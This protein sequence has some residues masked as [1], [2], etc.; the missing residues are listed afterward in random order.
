[1]SSKIALSSEDQD[2]GYGRG[3]SMSEQEVQRR[4]QPLKRM[5]KKVLL[6]G[7]TEMPFF[8]MTTN[9][10]E[11]DTTEE[12]SYVSPISGATLFSSEAKFDSGTG[13][14]SFTQPVSGGTILEREDPRDAKLPVEQ[15]RR[16]VLDAASMT[17]LGHVFEDG[18]P[19]TGRRYCIN[20]A[21]LRFETKGT[22]KALGIQ[23]NEEGITEFLWSLFP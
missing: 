8:G 19:P 16:E 7:D 2:L 6:Q 14:P 18:P 23:L 5:E 22:A 4:A 20:A 9:G 15:R 17:H 13:W 12:G 3:G 11:Y 21:A 1:M 10:Y